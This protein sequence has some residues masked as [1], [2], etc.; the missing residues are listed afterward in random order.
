M[1]GNYPHTGASDSKHLPAL[2]LSIFLVNTY[3]S[4]Q[5]KSLGL[6]WF[7]MKKTLKCKSFFDPISSNAF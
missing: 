5:L 2:I 4:Y 6:P 1:K 3:T 7:Y